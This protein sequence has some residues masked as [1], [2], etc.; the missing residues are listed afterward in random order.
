MGGDDAHDERIGDLSSLLEYREGVILALRRRFGPLRLD[1]GS[2]VVMRREV[3]L[4][5]ESEPLRTLG[6]VA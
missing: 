3:A 1:P 2:Q 6:Y 4:P 5:G